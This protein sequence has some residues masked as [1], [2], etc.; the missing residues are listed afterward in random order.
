MAKAILNEQTL[1]KEEAATCFKLFQAKLEAE[2]KKKDLLTSTEIKTNLE[3][4]IDAVKTGPRPSRPCPEP[5]LPLTPVIPTAYMAP[6]SNTDGAEDSPFTR[7]LPTVN[8]FTDPGIW[9]CL[10][11]GCNS[12]C[13][14]AQWGKNADEKLAKIGIKHKF[15]WLHQRSKVYNGIGGTKVH[16]YGKR[17][18]PAAWLLNKT[19]KILP[20][21]L[22]SQ[23]QDGRR[24]MLMSDESQCRMG[25]VKDMREGKIYLKDYDDYIDVYRAEGSGLKVVCISHF[26]QGAM[27]KPDFASKPNRK[28][29]S[30]SPHPVLVANLAV[31]KPDPP[32]PP[33][34]KGPKPTKDDLRICTVASLGLEIGRYGKKTKNS[35]HVSQYSIGDL[36]KYY[37]DVAK[38]DFTDQHSKNAIVK[39]FLEEHPDYE[40]C[41]F[42]LINCMSLDDPYHDK[43]L[44]GHTGYHPET[45]KHVAE[46]LPLDQLKMFAKGCGDWSEA[47]REGDKRDIVI[48]TVCKKERHRSVAARELMKTYLEGCSVRDVIIREGPQVWFPE[49]FCDG[50]YKICKACNHRGKEHVD[51]WKVAIK[52]FADRM[53]EVHDRLVWKKRKPDGSL[54]KKEPPPKEERKSARKI[55]P[56]RKSADDTP[57]PDSQGEQSA[58]RAQRFRR[59]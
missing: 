16:T 33:P 46:N 22:E 1:T 44:R 23:E 25:F 12:N 55:T 52:V 24:P 6:I 19:K 51:A 36:I 13:H 47:Q 50:K 59:I 20:G 26:P 37:G 14:G 17:R 32:E 57:A 18:M 41:R 56:R 11:E 38:I 39:R 30:L 54:Y 34:P 49:L 3:D 2:Y 42:V 28:E 40:Q 58:D 21:Y 48:L 7:E 35:D 53:K 4:S 9:V 45:M 27:N 29:R 5:G 10:D 15:D 8:I 43:K 31:T